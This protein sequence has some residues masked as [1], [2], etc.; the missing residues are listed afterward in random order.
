M[1]AP[2][3]PTPVSVRR[4][5]AEIGGR[6]V[7]ASGGDDATVVRGISHDSRLIE[8]GA[9]FCCVIGENDDGHRYAHDAIAAGALPRC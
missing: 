5:A 2:P 3:P 4:L 8:A 6:V 9:L 1:S 7:A